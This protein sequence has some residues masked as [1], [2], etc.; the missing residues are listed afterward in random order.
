MCSVALRHLGPRLTIWPHRKLCQIYESHKEQA[1]SVSRLRF[2][3]KAKLCCECW[4]ERENGMIYQLSRELRVVKSG[5]ISVLRNGMRLDLHDE[6]MLRVK[7]Q[8][9]MVSNKALVEV[10]SSGIL[11]L[12]IQSLV[13]SKVKE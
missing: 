2:H 9:Q 12:I 7:L 6:V 3:T 4:K 10:N 1:A 11:D 13:N 5:H 8:S